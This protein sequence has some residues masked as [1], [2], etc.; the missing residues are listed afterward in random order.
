MTS[1][2]MINDAIMGTTARRQLNSTLIEYF[3]R[4]SLTVAAKAGSQA[5]PV[6]AALKRSS[7]S[8]QNQAC[9]G[10]RRYATRN[11][12]PVFVIAASL[13]LLS[14]FVQAQPQNQTQA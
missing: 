12:A 3:L 8:R 1:V 2:T 6:I 13:C 7:P 5:K 14:L 9:R 10:P 11:P 4:Y